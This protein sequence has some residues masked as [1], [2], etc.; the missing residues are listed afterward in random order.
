M[1]EVKEQ[2]NIFQGQQ[3]KIGVELWFHKWADWDKLSEEQKAELIAHREANSNYSGTWT[4]KYG[5]TDQQPNT[6]RNTNGRKGRYLTKAQ[7]ASLLK[8][9]D[10]NKERASDQKVELIN[11]IRSQ[12]LAMIFEQG[13]G[14]TVAATAAGDPASII[15]SV[16]AAVGSTAAAVDAD[17]EVSKAN[18][19]NA[20]SAAE[21]LLL[22][23]GSNFSNVGSKSKNK[24]TTG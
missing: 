3:R 7:V 15:G 23:F 6:N 17:T 14:A 11:E 8:E 24:Q 20:E 2:E 22:K 5:D 9:H 16:R 1:D 21:S 13:K 19:T 12:I 18:D 10:S 4:G